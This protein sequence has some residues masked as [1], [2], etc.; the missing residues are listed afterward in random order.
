MNVP[1]GARL[2]AAFFVFGILMCALTLILLAAP[3][4]PLDMAWRLN[5]EAHRSFEK[6]GAFSYPLMGVVG[7]A[8][9]LAALGIGRGREWGRRVGITVL[10]MNL[11]GNIVGAAIRNDPRTLIGIP[12]A[13]MMIW[14]LARVRFSDPEVLQ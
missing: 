6:M 5:P 9:F 13:G 2:I 11:I 8:C 7:I 1:I 14:Y 3:G 4:T 10:V 12:I